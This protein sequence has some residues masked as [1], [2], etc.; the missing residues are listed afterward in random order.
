MTQSQVCKLALLHHTLHYTAL[1]YY[2]TRTHS[3]VSQCL[4]NTT[5]MR[6]TDASQCHTLLLMSPFNRPQFPT[7]SIIALLS[8]LDVSVSLKQTTNTNTYPRFHEIMGHSFSHVC[9]G[10]P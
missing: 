5:S 1:H 6:S 9:T 7:V 3:N 2:T 10:D 4:L 8:T